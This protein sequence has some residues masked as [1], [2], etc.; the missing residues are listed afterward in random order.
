MK[1]ASG[2]VGQRGFTLVELLVS[3]GIFL[4]VTGAAFSLLG[5]SQKHSQTESQVLA[6]FQE[7]RLGLDQIVRDVNDAGFPPPTFFQSAYPYLSASA[8]FAWSPGYAVPIPCQ[9]GGSC[10]TP[11]DFDIIIETN[12][13]P[14]DTG[15]QVQWIRYKLQGTTLMRGMAPKATSHDPLAD[16]DAPG[17]LAPFVQNVINN[18][19]PAQIAQYQLSYPGMFPGGVPV[20]I[21]SYTCDTVTVPA[22]CPSA[23]T[24]NAPANIR[25]VIVT[26]IVAA[27]APDATTGVPR[28]V[29]L[30]GRGRRVN[31][32]Q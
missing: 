32:N 12:P 1:W 5:S 30:T 15:S 9:I 6:S 31:P 23:G 27:P 3:L 21:F 26:L 18:S 20:P 10:F 7:A 14:Q 22:A 25:E 19:S 24:A 2:K 13:N 28:I 16:T 17:V 11:G 4:V 8:P 29:Q